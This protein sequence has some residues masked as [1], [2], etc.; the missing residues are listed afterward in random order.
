ME[1]LSANDPKSVGRWRLL[2]RLGKGGMGRVYFA[3]DASK[4]INNEV[5][6]KIIRSTVLEESGSRARL[7]REVNSLNS[8]TS[9]YV[10]RIVDSDINSSPAWIAT[11]KINGPSLAQYVKEH[12]PLDEKNWFAL[13]FGVFSAIDEIHRL[14][15]IHRDI[16]PSNILVEFQAGQIIPKIIDFGIAI[17]NE[18]TSITRTG[19]MIGTPAW[20]AP[21]QFTGSEVTT[22]VDVFATGSVL[23]FAA[24]GKNPWGIED[25]TPIASVIGAITAGRAELSEIKDSRRDL[26]SNLLDADPKNRLSAKEAFLSVYNLMNENGIR[27]N[28][29]SELPEGAAPKLKKRSRRR[30]VVKPIS[31][32]LLLLVL[33]SAM[34]IF[35]QSSQPVEAE[36]KVSISSSY[37]DSTCRG[38]SGMAGI[39]NSSVQIEDINSKERFNLGK[40]D[41]GIKK[42]SDTCEYSF[43]FQQISDEG[44]VYR[45]SLRFPW[46]NYVENFKFQRNKEGKLLFKLSLVLE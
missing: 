5:A 27:I 16:K 2:G 15:I 12:G 31:V 29:L 6:L 34:F 22:A 41:S 14:G 35:I 32:T 30:S 40:L 39:E 23:H 4:S 24:T 42:S 28:T 26:L 46:E 13:A 9:H 8:I 44:A 33:M 11:E 43:S 10:A 20:L 7:A 1:E 21:E 17:D 37:F 19:I 25:T 18:S 3:I 36:L 45:L 38:I